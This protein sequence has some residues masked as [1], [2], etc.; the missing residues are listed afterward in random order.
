M[1]AVFPTVPPRPTV[2]R[3]TARLTL[4]PYA[5]ADAPAFFALLD[6]NRARLQVAFPTRTATTRT[7][8][9]AARALAA[10]ADDWSAARL[11]VFGIWH[12]ATGRY[13]GDISLRPGPGPVRSAEIGYYL[14]CTA[15]G[16]GYAREALAAAV[17]FG[18]TDLRL[19]RLDIRCQA[20]NPRSGAVAEANGFR[21]L[22]L[23]PRLWPLRKQVADKQILYYELT[24]SEQQ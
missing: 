9:A 20:D 16:H 1:P 8:A 19:T 15:E 2:G 4:R 6:H 14:D 7:L 11:Y 22:P 12:T 23:R 13:L 10:F 5:E 24:A 17:A 18:L 21:Q 3:R